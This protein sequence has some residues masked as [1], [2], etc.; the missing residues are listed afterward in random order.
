MERF[1][2]VVI[3]GGM[4]GAA[5]ALTLANLGFH[6]AVVE[7][8]SPTSFSPAQA[9]DLRVSAISL[10]SQQLLEQ[11][12]AWKEI[13]QWRSCQ[14]NR[15]AVWE[16]ESAFTTFDSQDIEHS[17]LGTIVENRLIQLSLWQQLKGNKNIHLF[18]P[19]Q[20]V[21]IEQRE[22]SAIIKLERSVLCAKLIIGADGAQSKV[23]QLSHIGTTGWDYQQSAIVINVETSLLQQNITW[24][25]FTPSGPVAFLPLPGESRLGGFASLVWYHKNDEVKRLSTLSPAV[26]RDE[27]LGFFPSRIG[28][29]KVIDHASF[30]LTRRHA[31]NYLKG[32]VLLIGDAAH[33]INP[34]AGQGV[35]LGFRD[36]NALQGIFATA[37]S[38]GECWHKKEVLARYEKV[39]RS[40][41]L[42]MMSAMDMLYNVFTHPSPFIEIARNLGFMATQKIPFINGTLKRKALAYACGIK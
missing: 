32:K 38:N 39:R 4:I 13:Q 16:H 14:Y 40:D 2:C 17:H 21:A 22:Q 10:A 18:C 15:L 6:V 24:Q 20:L 9:L 33:T 5:S 35:N 29:I 27:I 23:R 25:K 19:E 1:D 42:L 7:I 26:L 11:L 28:D 41:N 8:S 30:P 31:N 37:I 12:D 3:G 36:V 34:L